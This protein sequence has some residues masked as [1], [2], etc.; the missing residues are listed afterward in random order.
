MNVRLSDCS[1]HVFYKQGGEVI[2]SFCLWSFFLS[3]FSP[4]ILLQMY[5]HLHVLNPALY[6][7]VIILLVVGTTLWALPSLWSVSN[8]VKYC[9]IWRNKARHT[10]V[11]IQE[12]VRFWTYCCRSGSSRIVISREGATSRLLSPL[13]HCFSTFFHG[14]TSKIILIIARNLLFLETCT[15]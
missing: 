1:V 9:V 14:G 6:I 15:G 2:S 4:W 8:T 7:R 12:R 10:M 3:S 13:D 5:F 11:Y